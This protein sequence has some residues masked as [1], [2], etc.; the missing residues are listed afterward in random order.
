MSETEFRDW[1]AY[2][3]IEPFG[4]EA[5]FYRSGIVAA[6]IANVNRDTKTH[7]EPFSPADFMPKSKR[8]EEEAEKQPATREELI[9]GLESV[10][11]ERFKKKDA[12]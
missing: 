8:R 2:F 11:G 6:T 1:Q 7:P 12:D 9:G 4:E 3:A 10:F 5:A